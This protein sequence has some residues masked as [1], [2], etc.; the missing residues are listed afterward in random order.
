M[1]V[2]KSVLG[3]VKRA[4][5][6]V[7]KAPAAHQLL[8]RLTILRAALSMRSSLRHSSLTS[9]SGKAYPSPAFSLTARMRQPIYAT[10]E[11]RPAMIKKSRESTRPPSA[12]KVALYRVGAA[13]KKAVSPSW[14]YTPRLKNIEISK[15]LHFAS[16]RG[17]YTPGQG[18]AHTQGA[19]H[20]QSAQRPPATDLSGAQIRPFTETLV[21]PPR[22]RTAVPLV[23]SHFSQQA[24]SSGLN[25]SDNE[26]ALQYLAAGRRLDGVGVDPVLLAWKMPALSVGSQRQNIS[27]RK[28]LVQRSRSRSKK[29]LGKL[30]IN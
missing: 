21:F 3:P 18:R 22:M 4:V 7:W 28:S 24:S 1:K 12:Q 10:A 15:S 2:E 27:D 9:T 5:D 25:D 11:F 17:V 26:A 30:L 23:R 29:L 6:K 14:A 16:Q 19:L 20:I 13:V 8:G